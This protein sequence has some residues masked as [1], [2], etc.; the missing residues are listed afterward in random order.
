MR[1]ASKWD[2]VLER[3]PRPVLD[4][5]VDEVAQLFAAELERWPPAVEDAAEGSLASLL[6]TQPRRPDRRVYEAAFALARWDLERE[7]EAIDD[8]FRN[9]RYLGVGLA[10]GDRALLLFM[11]RLIVEHLLALQEATNGRLGRPR[12][13]EVLDRTRQA[14]SAAQGTSREKV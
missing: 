9:Q 11:S 10:P 14:L 4:Y 13:I 8:Y 1:L 5:L 6:V 2:L 3:R 7:V 12:L